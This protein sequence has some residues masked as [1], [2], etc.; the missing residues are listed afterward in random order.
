MARN[1]EKAQAMLNRFMQFKRDEQRIP[2]QKRPHLA[3]LCDNLE[4]CSKWRNQIIKEITKKVAIIQN[5]ALGEH[6]IRD[7]N[8]TINKLVGT[9]KHWERQIKQLGG[10]DY[11]REG[12]RIAD[13]DGKRAFGSGGY[14]YFG[15]AKELPGVREL[16]DQIAADNAPKMTRYELHKSVDADYYGYRDDDDGLLAKLEKAEEQKARVKAA[17]KFKKAE[18]AM[19]EARLKAL[20]LTAANDDD[21]EEMGSKISGGSSSSSS[22]SSGGGKSM[23]VA[24]GGGDD[25][26]GDAAMGGGSGGSEPRA[27]VPLPDDTQL[28]QLLLQRRKQLLL[29]K[30]SAELSAPEESAS[31]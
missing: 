15:A 9:K 29:A 6:K 1:Q 24:N 22:S 14:F 19:K 2:E 7:L 28:Q 11:E 13:A 3:T 5:G 31:S 25:G 10:P 23:F 17:E 30:Y 8:D 16:F 26:D 12:V 27:H 18:A 20:N 21:D 4:E